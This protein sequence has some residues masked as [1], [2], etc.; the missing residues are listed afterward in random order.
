MIPIGLIIFNILLLA[1]IASSIGIVALV[2]GRRLDTAW[3][4][5]LGY[6]GL[7]AAW[8]M[9]T[10][11]LELNSAGLEAK[12]FWGY[13]Q[14]ISK[15]FMP[16]SYFMFT[17]AYTENRWFR[18]ATRNVLLIIPILSLIFLWF[19]VNDLMYTDVQLVDS[20]I[21]PNVNANYGWWFWVFIVNTYTLLLAG[22]GILIHTFLTVKH[23]LT[24]IQIVI[25]AIC[26]ILP[27]VSSFFTIMDIVEVDLAPLF[28]GAMA[29]IMA[30]ALLRLRMFDIEPTR[31][32]ILEKMG[33]GFLSID[34]NNRVIDFNQTAK[35]IL[36]RSAW[37]MRNSSLDSLDGFS[38]E[39]LIELNKPDFIGR[40][41]DTFT[42][43]REKVRFAIYVSQLLE[44][45]QTPYGRLIF[46]R[47][48]TKQKRLEQSQQDL[49]RSVVHDLRSPIS[50]IIGLLEMLEEDIQDGIFNPEEGVDIL[51]RS[52]HILRNN[53]SI[54]ERALEMNRIDSGQMQLSLETV[55]VEDI[56]RQVKAI[57]RPASEQKQISL[58]A[59][60]EADLPPVEIDRMAIARVVQNLIDNGIKFSPDGG[61][62][63]L[64][65]SEMSEN[66]HPQIAISIRDSGPGIPK[67][68]HH[69]L[70]EKFV[71]GDQPDHGFGLGLAYCKSVL[72][73]H[74]EMIW[75][76]HSSS[77][78][79]TFTFTLPVA[80]VALLQTA[81]N[82]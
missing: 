32:A 68:Q 65:A 18:P 44:P 55:T 77:E 12:L 26:S 20:S 69:L 35:Q 64:T 42:I 54:I 57:M 5:P 72:D 67:D 39:I 1:G 76:D 10:Y 24:R 66:G 16:V 37:E 38:E 6:L 29:L 56:W 22:A 74:G 36:K 73:A 82:K 49:I 2:I 81:P 53:I 13:A 7:I 78:G 48:I 21:G 43:N 62:I 58:E 15:V 60:I 9:G 30:F 40:L 31:M 59:Q 75:L 8:F 3:A 52:N 47:D 11:M 46:M 41:E 33:D 45:D 25:L 17:L 34:L 28:V 71:H 61:I 51:Q 80:P 23:G 79:T 50:G 27:G 14:Y 19:D 4:K 63:E 70:F